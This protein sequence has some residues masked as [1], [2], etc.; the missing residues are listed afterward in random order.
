MTREHAKSVGG[1]VAEAGNG[2]GSFDVD[3][4]VWHLTYGNPEDTVNGQ[5]WLIFN[6]IFGWT[7]NATVGTILSY[8]FYWLA[9]IAALVYMKWQE[10]RLT[11]KQRE[12]GAAKRAAAQRDDHDGAAGEK[13]KD[14]GSSETHSHEPGAQVI[15]GSELR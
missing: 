7:N 3:G 5:G 1:D 2:P 15:G 13:A 12:A 8:V 9:V 10:G 6:S 11:K 4:N 14:D